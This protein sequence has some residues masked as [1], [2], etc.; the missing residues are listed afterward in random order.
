[1]QTFQYTV[2]N[3]YKNNNFVY[4]WIKGKMIQN[5]SDYWNTW[6]ILCPL[7]LNIKCACK[8]MLFVW[9]LITKVLFIC[10]QASGG[11][12]K[13][14]SISL[15]HSKIKVIVF[16]YFEAILLLHF[17]VWLKH[18]FCDVLF[19]WWTW[20][21]LKLKSWLVMAPLLNNMPNPEK[22]LRPH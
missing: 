15:K 21:D 18:V 3:I 4:F 1:M 8:R 13:G 2:I 11:S 22:F 10:F 14:P 6:I 5:S 20:Q 12:K 19:R 9:P 7:L 16:N 17:F